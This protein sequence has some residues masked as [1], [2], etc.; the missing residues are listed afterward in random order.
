MHLTTHISLRMVIGVLLVTTSALLYL[1]SDQ[2]DFDSL[3]RWLAGHPLAAPLWFL[4]SYTLLSLFLLPG[5]LMSVIGGMLF[6]PLLGSLLNQAGAIV[7]ALFEFAL[8]RYLARDW[9]ERRLPG[10]IRKYKEGVDR[11]GW[12]FVLLVRIVPGL[13]YSFLNYVFGVTRIHLGHFLAATFVCILPRIVTYSVLGH[14]GRL[15]ISGRELAI[16]LAVGT[17]LLALFFVLPYVLLAWWRQLRD[18]PER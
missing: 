9:V 17:A 10:N 5:A 13:P 4:L 18:R 7:A 6:G 14:A 2:I 8:G 12:R 3:G 15:A 16:P 11:E 1:N